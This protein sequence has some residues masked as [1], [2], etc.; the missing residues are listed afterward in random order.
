MK[1]IIFVF[2][3]LMSALAVKA[4]TDVVSVLDAALDSLDAG[5]TQDYQPVDSAYLVEIEDLLAQKEKEVLAQKAIEQTELKMLKQEMSFHIDGMPLLRGLVM[6]YTEDEFNEHPGVF[7]KYDMDKQDYGVVLLPLAANWVLKA[8][9]VESR[10]KTHRMLVAN[11]MAV[12]IS[13]GITKTMKI[14]FDERRPDGDG[15]DAFP[16]GHSSLA[17]VGATILHR[18]Y[19]HI[20]PWISVGGYATATASQMLRLKHNRHWAHDT[21]VGA[22]IGAMST[23]LA[24]FLTDKIFGEDGINRPRLTQA[25]MMRVLKFA[26][27]PSSI[28]FI[29]GT[30]VGNR[31]ID[32]DNNSSLYVGAGF[33]AGVEGSLFLNRYFALEAM[34][35]Y[36]TSH[37]K[38]GG[39]MVDGNG[40][41]VYGGA[42]A[43]MDFF[44]FNIGAKFSVPYD[45]TNRFSCRV[46]V[47]TRMLCDADFENVETHTTL[48]RL[49]GEVKFDLGCGLSYDCVTTKKYAFG[50]NFDYHHTFSDIMP[51]RYGMSTVW[52]ILL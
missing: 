44:R 37:A 10:S 15:D 50:F 13:A 28:S 32:L 29:S 38:A 52:K 5:Q 47:G 46:L 14:A 1:N 48:L 22:G 30:E 17:F 2:L 4:Q 40:G 9:G 8:A 51:N 19:G 45:M 27:N 41:V 49:P 26:E 12:A 6:K 18:E 20:S 34:G 7:K 43:N 35:K 33:M 23:N 21:F 24:Y 42:T 3:S 16:S 39:R 25:D 31:T 11:A 36:V